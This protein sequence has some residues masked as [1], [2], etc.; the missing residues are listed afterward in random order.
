MAPLYP[1]SGYIL[2]GGTDK[3]LYQLHS[4]KG[5]KKISWL[6]CIYA[7][8]TSRLVN[9]DKWL[10]HYTHQK[11]NKVV[12]RVTR[13]PSVRKQRR[14]PHARCQTRRTSTNWWRRRRLNSSAGSYNRSNNDYNNECK[15]S[16]HL[17]LTHLLEIL[18]LGNL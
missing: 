14:Y 17:F 2:L 1:C 12:V 16:R 18:S 13:R 3:W 8:V 7:L 4:F 6:T 5:K 9:T 10:N 11:H 15:D